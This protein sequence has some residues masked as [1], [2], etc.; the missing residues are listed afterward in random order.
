MSLLDVVGVYHCGVGWLQH[1][2]KDQ[3]LQQLLSIRDIP[4]AIFTDVTNIWQCSRRSFMRS[5][6]AKEVA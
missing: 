3:E 1:R 6:L 2:E 4:F 5:M